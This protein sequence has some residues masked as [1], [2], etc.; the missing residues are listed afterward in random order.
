MQCIKDAQ[1]QG[2][3]LVVGGERYKHTDDAYAQGNWLLPAIIFHSDK[4]P[5]VMEEET[6]APILRKLPSL[7]PPRQY[8]VVLR[9]PH[10][11]HLHV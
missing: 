2:G 7:P 6:F 5:Q 1:A 8:R 9:Q 4:H 10:R 11:R 3:R